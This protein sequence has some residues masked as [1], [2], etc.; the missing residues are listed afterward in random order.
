MAPALPMAGVAGSS[1]DGEMRSLRMLGL[2]AVLIV[3]A[4][5]IATLVLFIGTQ[6]RG[7][8][9]STAVA[10]A[11]EVARSFWNANGTAM[12][13][14]FAVSNEVMSGQIVRNLDPLGRAKRVTIV[15]E[16]ARRTTVVVS[17]DVCTQPTDGLTKRLMTDTTVGTV[18]G[19]A[20][21]TDFT[22]TVSPVDADCDTPAPT[23]GVDAFPTLHATSG[24]TVT[25]DLSGDAWIDCRTSYAEQTQTVDHAL[26]D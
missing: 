13:P 18:N 5:A 21:V 23:S 4:A 17:L 12:Q 9:S 11:E 26:D 15:G 22:F 25:P 7:R 10:S 14:S 24:P 19:V 20:K 8:S 3:G 2:A 1:V 6:G 16:D